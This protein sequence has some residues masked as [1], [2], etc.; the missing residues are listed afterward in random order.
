MSEINQNH[1]ETKTIIKGYACCLKS[2]VFVS[3]ASFASI[4]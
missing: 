1:I 4:A 2:G 3:F